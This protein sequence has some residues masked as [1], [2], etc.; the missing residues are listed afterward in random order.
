MNKLIFV[1]GLCVVTPVAAKPLSKTA[2]VQ[3]CVKA[4]EQALTC[5]EQFIDAMIDLRA[6]HQPE[7]AEAV[8][9]DRAAVR[10]KGLSE[11][12]VDGGGPIAERTKLCEETISE[13][14]LPDEKEVKALDVCYAKS[15]CGAKV[16]CMITA[17]ER[18]MW[19]AR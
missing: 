10:A 3:S 6:K 14:P 1:F 16:E 9:K 2:A 18:I 4:R 11:M 15:A 17:F 7:M 19:P 12:A 8:K 5:K 13:K